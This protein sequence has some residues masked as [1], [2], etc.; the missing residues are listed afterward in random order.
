MLKI[1]HYILL[2]GLLALAA[3]PGVRAQGMFQ[4]SKGKVS[5]FS[6]APL[7][8]ITA[9]N[10]APAG[11]IN[12]ANGELAIKMRI[13]AFSFPNKLMQ[14]HFNE[15]YLHSDKFPTATFAGRV[16]DAGVLQKP[17]NWNV[18]ITGKLTIHGVT[19]ER[20]LPA[21]LSV[22][23][24]QLTLN[25]KFM[26]KLADHGVEIPTIVVKKIAEEVEVTVALTLAPKP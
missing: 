9:E 15:N 23:K 21:T 13:D 2:L 10:A 26:V 20:T 3:T 7:E 24:D 8:D 11:L 18:Q 5:F 22:Q 6:T 12:T 16:M 14:E 4:V 25:G 1:A 17:G 19:V